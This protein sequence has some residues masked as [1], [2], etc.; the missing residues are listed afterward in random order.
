M[1][2]MAQIPPGLEL[3]VLG[4]GPAY[5]D[6][7][8]SIGASYLVRAG[9]AALVL[10]L[11]QGAFPALAGAVDPLTLTAVVIS[12]LHPD[13]FIDLVPLRH[14]VCRPEAAPLRRVRVIAPRGLDTRLD[15]VYDEP[16]FTAGA[17]E[18]IVP[19]DGPL[20][21]GP[22]ELRSARVRHAGESR[23]WRVGPIEGRAPGVV[24][25]GD[26][27]DPAAIAP[28]VRPGDTLLSEATY[29][30]GPVPEGMPHLDGPMVGR[31]AAET[32]AGAVVVTHVSMGRDLDATVAAVRAA[33]DGPVAMARPGDRYAIVPPPRRPAG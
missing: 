20:R 15:A 17:F 22:F 27:S 2:G 33:Y 7:A 6:I 29:G 10:D 23:A 16:G 32:R 14:Y 28:L 1:G 5:S 12:H 8:G 21:T 13:H 19:A 3:H 11:G 18:L 26:A 9:T 31:L 30:A 24:Y 25:T 4:A